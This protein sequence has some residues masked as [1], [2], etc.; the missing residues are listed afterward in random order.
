[1]VDS[2]GKEQATS[3]AAATLAA[4]SSCSQ[5]RMHWTVQTVY[6]SY[7]QTSNQNTQITKK[8]HT[9]TLYICSDQSFVKFPLPLSS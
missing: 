5:Q 2:P 4:S 8:S 1:M 6:H 9:L 3:S 7:L